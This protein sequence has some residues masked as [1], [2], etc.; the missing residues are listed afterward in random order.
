MKPLPPSPS[1]AGERT[2]LQCKFRLYNYHIGFIALPPT[3]GIFD[4]KQNL[5]KAGAVL[6]WPSLASLRSQ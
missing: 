5:R 1:A 3:F 6:G 2:L 4:K